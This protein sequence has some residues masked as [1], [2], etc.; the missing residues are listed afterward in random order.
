MAEASRKKTKI[1]EE[2]LSIDKQKSLISLFS[3]AD[4]D[5]EVRK[6]FLHLSQLQALAELE[7]N[8]DPR[9]VASDDNVSFVPPTPAP[10]HPR[11]PAGTHPAVQQ[12]VQITAGPSSTDGA[13]VAHVT[14]QSQAQGNLSLIHI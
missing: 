1:A 13:H 12:Q 5:P 14:D 11:I 10:S 7:T 2:A 6:R 9:L 4:T 3:M 8:C